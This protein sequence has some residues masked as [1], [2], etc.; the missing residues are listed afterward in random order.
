MG[1]ILFSNITKGFAWFAFLLLM[2]VLVSLC[3]ASAPALHQF[4]FHFLVS[5]VWDPVQGHFGALSAIC[6]TLMTSIIAMLLGVPLSLGIAVFISEISQ[7][8][9]AKT[10]RT[11]IDLMAGIP[12]IIYGMWGLLVLAPF[13]ANYIQPFITDI[14]Q[15][16]PILNELF[17]G[18]P[19]GIGIF[20]AGLI[21][22]IMIIP[23][24]SSTLIDMF[25]SVPAVLKEA[26]YGV[27]ATR[28]EVVWK[29][30][31]PYVRK[32]MIGSIMLGLGRALGETM[33]V[34]FVIGNSKQLTSSLF[35]P[36]T[37]ISASI[38]N[39]FNEATGHLYP[40]SLLELGVILF[41]LSFII[42]AFARLFLLRI[43]R[44]KAGA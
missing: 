32:G 16:I 7:G 31:I 27:G 10:V 34:T 20:T 26:A 25:R 17:G 21:L 4:G 24:I 8:K 36:G 3:F 14:C 41:V 43:N 35:M 5:D 37:T 11:L 33:A 18:P 44:K 30:V 39:E 12:S 38:A 40:A 28:F 9:I 19:L 13:L 22:A 2:C 1:D 29:V 42:L 23:Y 15:N 6:G